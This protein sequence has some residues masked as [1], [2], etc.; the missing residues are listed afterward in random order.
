MVA[1]NIFIELSVIIAIALII[2][3]IMKA[4]R[5]PLI[6]GYILTGLIISPYFF[7]LVKSVESISMLAQMGIA[8][9]L[10]MVGLNLNPKVIKDIGKV[11]VVTGLG[12]I[13]FTSLVGFGIAK[14][15][16][17]PTVAAVYIA[18]ALSFSS[19]II[20]M[21]LLSDKGDIQTLYGKI[22]IGFLIVQDIV[23]I[24]ALIIISSVSGSTD[25]SSLAFQKIGIGAGLVAALFLIG[26]YLLP[27]LTKLIAK[28]QEL[29]L[30]FSITWAFA[31]ASLFGY[32]GFSI[33]IG[34]LLAGVSLS[35]SPYRYEIGAKMKPLRDFFLLLF[36]ISLGSQITLS[37]VADYTLPLIIFSVFVLVGNPIIVMILMGMLGYTKKNSFLAGLT[38]SQISEFSFI[39]IALGVS[40]GHLS[41]SIL[42]LVTTIGLITMAGSS[43]SILHS[44]GIYNR[45]SKYLRIFEK[46]GKKVDEGKYHKDEDYDIILFGY[47]RIGF[48]LEKAFKKMKKKFLVVD[49]NPETI[50]RLA[51]AKVDCRYGDAEDCELL[52]DLPLEKAKMIISTIPDLATSLLL[53]EKIRA[54]NKKIILI[55]VSHQIE[56]SL[57]LYEAG[58]T[59]VITPHFFGGLHTAQLIDR[60]GFDKKEFVKEGSKNAHELLKRQVEGHKDVLHERD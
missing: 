41:P 5:Q 48:S 4:L 9:L 42:S 14:L 6:I 10:F 19:T 15:L 18:L 13:L 26:V 27:P 23:A 24:L 12:Q 28:S 21:K 30:L 31:L 37:S 51:K 45:I 22:S 58:A 17:F 57:Q 47:N 43:Y 36:F 2:S 49:N 55:V 52:D 35:V 40:V 3:L 44:R 59:Y 32:A 38:V 53:I 20:I 46:K 56:E 16:G 50:L 11:A 60:C 33:E 7:N 54:V 39:L 34:A 1:E 8:V 25:L 29:L